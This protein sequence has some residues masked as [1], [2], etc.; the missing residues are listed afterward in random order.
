MSILANGDLIKLGTFYLAGSKQARPTYPWQNGYTPS[1]APGAGNIPT[2]SAGQTI[3]IRDTDA[4]DAYKIQW[5][6]VNIDGKKLLVAD[7]NLLVSVSWDDLNAQSLIFGKTI[8]I[9][10]QQYKVRALTGGSNYR[11]TSDAYV[12]GTPTNNEWDRI[13][14]NESAFTSLPVPVST[15][16]DSTLNGTDRLSSH[17]QFWN[18]YYCYS[19]A[20]ET[21]TGNGSYRA[22]RG[23]YS[24]RYWDIITSSNR[25]AGYG[26]RPVLEVLNS[27]PVISGSDQN[28]GNK[29]A[30][31]SIN[32]TVSD[33]ESDAVNIVEKINGTTVRSE[34]GVAQ[35]TNREITLDSEKWKDL[36]LNQAITIVIEATDS[37]GAKSTRTYTFTK[38]N[39]APGISIVEPKG[40][41]ANIA[42]VNTLTPVLVWSFQDTDSGDIQSAYQVIIE[43]TNGNTIHDS[44]KVA[45]SQS[46]YQVPAS[47]LTWGV[48]YKY[49]VKVW[50]KY[51]V[52]SEFSFEEFFLPNRPPNVTNV[53]PGS[54]DSNNPV[55][56]GT[57]PEFT[58]VFADLDLEAQAAYQLKVYKT[59]D[60][61]L[62]YNSNRINQSVN[63]HLVPSNALIEGTDYYVVVTVWDPNNLSKDSD[64]SYFRTNATPT[65]PALVAPAD[66]Y[67]TSVN[68]IFEAIVGTDPEDNGQHFVIQ[69]AE[70]VNFT[71]GVLLFSSLEDR[72]GWKV[73]GFDIPLEGVD[74]A[75][76]G[77]TVAYTTQ[78]S[79]AVNK[80]Y[81]W[82]IAAIDA[83]TTAR[84]VWSSVRK[85]R[86]GNTLQFMMKN[87]I[88]TSDTAANR[89]LSALDYFLPL[90]GNTKATIKVEVSNNA[91]D[92]E[93]TWE[94]ATEQFK[95]MDYYNFTNVLKTS[96][97]FAVA[98]KVTIKAND[99]LDPI[100]V[101][102]LGM[103]FD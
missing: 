93:P 73:N 53:A 34:N 25:S 9:D 4:S 98:V 66:N 18:W 16:L 10:G 22:F 6:E 30:P 2:F 45:S 97:H 63:R 40:N 39:A 70:D 76:Q 92:I 81:Y 5:R 103:T 85:F 3:E 99:A 12:G 24:A 33:A 19:W 102:A 17:N 54:A 77:R 58:W 82:R 62:V 31:F 21:Y 65:A 43:D 26:W 71:Q 32:Y 29:T 57:I 13:I 68:P 88:V 15:D 20:Q 28:L 48:K 91:A 79:L 46:F 84:G 1:G 7:R 8:T 94:D 90:D 72:V 37:K 14:T 38:T 95:N 44:T 80:T 101:D 100:Y 52:S 55:G 42:I 75:S 41:L 49:R 47:V 64:K 51:D 36:P 11:N 61:T 78:L 59:S 87:P 50:D 27:A 60:N 96:S 67:R 23:Y 83:S 35:N 69:L 56:T 74:N 86:C 89:V